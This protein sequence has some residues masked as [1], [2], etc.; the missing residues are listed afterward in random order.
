[1]NDD[2]TTSYWTSLNTMQERLSCGTLVH[3]D[4]GSRHVTA[5]LQDRSVIKGS[6]GM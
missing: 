6:N 3:Y 1:M 2:T 4:K 5:S